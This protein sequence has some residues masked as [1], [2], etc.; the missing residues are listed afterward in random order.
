VAGV[1]GVWFFDDHS[2]GLV[3]GSSFQGALLSSFK[4]RATP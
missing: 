4:A 3:A 1:F 2:S